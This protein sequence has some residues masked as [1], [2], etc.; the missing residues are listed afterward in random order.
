[1]IAKS[2]WEDADRIR[3]SQ[4]TFLTKLLSGNVHQGFRKHRGVERDYK[5]VC[6]V[7]LI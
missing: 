6:S 1:M 3:W 2:K 4:F 7:I 5:S